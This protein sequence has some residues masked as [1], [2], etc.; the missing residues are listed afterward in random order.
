MTIN[1]SQ[2]KSSILQIFIH[3][4]KKQLLLGFYTHGHFS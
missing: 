4:F 1:S 2:G 3:H